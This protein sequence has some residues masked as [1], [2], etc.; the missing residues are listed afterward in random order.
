MAI[1]GLSRCKDYERQAVPG[2]WRIMHNAIAAHHC[3]SRQ[4]QPLQY[5]LL[6]P[7]RPVVYIDLT[8]A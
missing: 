7:R 1:M 4:G 8:L 5:V 3:D 6:C 2:G